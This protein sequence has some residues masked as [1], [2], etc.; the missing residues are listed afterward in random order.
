MLDRSSAQDAIKNPERREMEWRKLR[1]GGTAVRNEVREIKG[2]R[3]MT[4]RVVALTTVTWASLESAKKWPASLWPQ[5]SDSLEV[6]KLQG[7]AAEA[8]SQVGK[9][10]PSPSDQWWW[11][12]SEREVRGD[13]IPGS[14]WKQSW[15]D[16]LMDWMWGRKEQSLGWH[17]FCFLPGLH[18]RY[19]SDPSEFQA[20]SNTSSYVPET[21]SQH[22][23][24]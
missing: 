7:S 22:T 18:T 17:S 24:F 16:L 6:C 8:G 19:V 14:F 1:V 23:M 11:S 5:C 10:V 13:P 20:P 3:I 21:P 4:R 9:P 2:S 15:Y 12:G